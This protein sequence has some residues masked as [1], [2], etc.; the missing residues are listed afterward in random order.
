MF[1]KPE[2]IGLLVSDHT[3][4]T[5]VKCHLSQWSR[6][7]V[8]CSLISVR[9]AAVYHERTLDYPCGTF[10]L[11][12]TLQEDCSL[13][14]AQA[15]AFSSGILDDHVVHDQP[16]DCREGTSVPRRR[17]ASAWLYIP[18]SFVNAVPGG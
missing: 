9:L 10:C 13:L 14:T 17:L 4:H 2:A 12:A 15:D 7:A 5:D 6:R 1:F 3:I 11:H 18:R 8:R 16:I